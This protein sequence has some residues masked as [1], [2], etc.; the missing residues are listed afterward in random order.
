V[1][2]A[3]GVWSD[4]AT[5]LLWLTSVGRAA[6]GCKLREPTPPARLHGGGGGGGGVATVISSRLL[7]KCPIRSFHTHST[8]IVNY[9]GWQHTDV[10][11]TVTTAAAAEGDKTNVRQRAAILD[12][13]WCQLAVAEVRYCHGAL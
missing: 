10:N 7:S 12:W 5:P 8:I 3:P 13:V 11:L 2:G 4:A 6:A 1:V 9:C